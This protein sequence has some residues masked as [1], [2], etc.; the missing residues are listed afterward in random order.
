MALCSPVSKST[1]T[2]KLL[3]RDDIYSN[4]SIEISVLEIAEKELFHFEHLANEPTETD[5][6][7]GKIAQTL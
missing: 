2:Y 4:N 7:I 3:T 1:V 5:S 6:T